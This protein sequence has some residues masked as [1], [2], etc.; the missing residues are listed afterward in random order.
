M[1][2]SAIRTGS[3]ADT[4]RESHVGDNT[5]WRI[6]RKYQ[7]QLNCHAVVRGNFQKEV[8][9]DS[10][11]LYMELLVVMDPTIY[12]NEI[13]E[14]LASGM[15]LQNDELPSIAT[16]SRFPLSQNI[17]RK[18]CKKVALKRFTPENIVRRRAFIQW[19]SSVD[20]RKI[21]VVDETRIEDFHRNF[22]RT[23]L[24]WSSP[25]NPLRW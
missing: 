22:G 10:V 1:I 12:L 8:I 19:R 15:G 4:A 6:V 5:A 20:Q 25:C 9:K 13:Q 16:I 24:V 14:R 23:I 17:T 18:K 21:F 2:K 7:E 3:I 11:Q